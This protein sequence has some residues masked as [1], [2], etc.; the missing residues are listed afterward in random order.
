MKRFFALTGL[1]F[2][3]S[4]AP[5]VC[6]EG[7]KLS[8]EYLVSSAPS[9][10]T[11]DLSV[12]YGLLRIPIKVVKEGNQFVVEGQ[13]KSYQVDLNSLCFGPT[14]IDLPVNPDG[15]IFG[16]L[17]RGE[18]KVQCG[19]GGVAFERDDGAFFSRFLFKEGK[20]YMAEFFDK[21][22]D[23]KV[24][25]EYLDWSKEGYAKALRVST[26]ELTFIITVDSL[27]RF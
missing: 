10:Y 22:K 5:M 25:L 23:S 11:A 1:L 20:P 18:E 4:C 21:K 24:V 14:C 8:K 15:I 3:F 19:L 13:G 7:S 12:R 9:S 6:P 17:L 16:K 27:R 2:A 26:G